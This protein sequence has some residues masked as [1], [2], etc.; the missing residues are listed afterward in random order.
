[1]VIFVV[2][3]LTLVLTFILGLLKLAFGQGIFCRRFYTA[4]AIYFL[5]IG[6]FYFKE[7]AY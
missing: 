4:Y 7:L 5:K 6:K 2:Y 1:M 3:Q